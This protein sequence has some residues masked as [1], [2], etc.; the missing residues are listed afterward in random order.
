M[1][2]PVLHQY[3]RNQATIMVSLVVNSVISKC[4]YSHYTDNKQGY[5]Y[6]PIQ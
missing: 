3:N 5:P 4:N 1:E 6:D 2:R